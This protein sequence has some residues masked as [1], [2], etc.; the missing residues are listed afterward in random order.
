MRGT[1]AE[2]EL[3]EHAARDMIR[4]YDFIQADC[5]SLA[6]VRA[7]AA[8]LEARLGAAPLDFLALTQARIGEGVR[9]RSRAQLPER[10]HCCVAVAVRCVGE[11]QG[12]A[13]TQG[14][15]PTADGLDQK[16]TLHY[17]RQ[18][19]RASRSISTSRLSRARK[20]VPRGA[21]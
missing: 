6:G 10:V 12:M 14:F 8:E 16:L 21:W 7:A 9:A 5:F 1:L 2:T 3:T 4:R 18:T 11:W 19:T 20:H 17:Y 13:T 15:T